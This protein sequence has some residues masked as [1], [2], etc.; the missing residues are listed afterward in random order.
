MLAIS[1]V[2]CDVIR[3]AVAW[4][5]NLNSDI[6]RQWISFPVLAGQHCLLGHVDFKSWSL[7][8]TVPIICAFWT[9]DVVEGEWSASRFIYFTP[10]LGENSVPTGNRTQFIQE[11]GCPVDC[12]SIKSGKILQTFRMYLLPPS[13]RRL[14]LFRRM[15]HESV[16][17][18]FTILFL[19]SAFITRGSNML[20]CGP[21]KCMH[22]FG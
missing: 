8:L 7:S 13:R 20:E 14:L 15:G 10:R 9:L 2:A 22:T 21:C 5:K 1:D 11:E 12:W 17:A 16:V 4:N 18:Y 3:G 19:H 6:G